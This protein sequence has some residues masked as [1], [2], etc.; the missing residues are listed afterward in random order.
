MTVLTKFS[1]L[2]KFDQAL[3]QDLIDDFMIH[4]M[5]R[6]EPLSDLEEKV[7]KPAPKAKKVVRVRQRKKTNR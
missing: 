6:S 7:I 1:D 4:A 5:K 2:D 3:V